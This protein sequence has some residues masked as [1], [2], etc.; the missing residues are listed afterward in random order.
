M[1]IV[2]F[3][4]RCEWRG[5]GQNAFIHRAGLI[6]DKIM[7]KRPS[8]IAFQEVIPQSL[9]VL[10]RLLPEYEF[11]GGM[12]T[13]RHDGE[14]LY[15]AILKDELLPLGFDL[16]WLSPA[17]HAVGSRFEN[18]SIFPRVGVYT[19]LVDKESGEIYS[20]FNLHLDY[21]SPDAA[22]SGL[23]CALDY[24][25]GRGSFVD[26]DRTI[27]LGD[28]NVMPDSPALAPLRAEAWL[29]DVTETLGPTFHAF[30]MRKNERG[31]REDVKIDYIFA[32][33]ALR[34]RIGEVSIWQDEHAGIYLS[35][36]YPVCVTID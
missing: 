24:I 25:H 12:R 19:R 36:H 23:A 3:N 16:F 20:I 28:F 27:I 34:A 29:Y 15:T 21:L 2:T 31:E 11:F 8:V 13:E 4:L 14:G 18:Q 26:A 6:Y 32:S 5:D 22:A 30:G 17:P 1:K 33:T 7:E 10:R 35:D 9:E